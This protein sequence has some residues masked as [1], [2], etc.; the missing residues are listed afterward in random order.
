MDFRL[1]VTASEWFGCLASGDIFNKQRRKRHGKGVMFWYE[2][3][4]DSK[5]YARSTTYIASFCFHRSCAYLRVVPVI[6]DCELRRSSALSRR[7]QGWY[8]CTKLEHN[9]GLY[10]RLVFFLFFFSSFFLLA[11]VVS[12]T[13]T[14]SHSKTGLTGASGAFGSIFFAGSSLPLVHGVVRGISCVRVPP[15]PPSSSVPGKYRI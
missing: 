5:W 13:T 7:H 15:P 4:R 6:W 2:L 12:I 11:I 1:R 8:L 3:F 14:R 10:H 9:G